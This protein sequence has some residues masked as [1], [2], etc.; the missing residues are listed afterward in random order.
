MEQIIIIDTFTNN[1]T[2]IT[3]KRITEAHKTLGCYKCIIRNELA[4]IEYLKLRSNTL[5]N[6]IRN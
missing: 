5:T 2:Y 3:Q 1:A 4:E 6:M